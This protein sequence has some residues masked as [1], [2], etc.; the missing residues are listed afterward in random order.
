MAQR[1]PP[2]TSTTDLS[3]IGPVQRPNT[4]ST[5]HSTT[6]EASV[7]V[8]VLPE[9]A[10][11]SFPTRRHEEPVTAAMSTARPTQDA[12]IDLTD[13]PP[14][15][16]VATT[17][18]HRS[19][20][21][22]SRVSS[23]Q[24][25]S[26]HA[27]V[28]DLDDEPD[29]RDV[30]ASLPAAP[31]S[32]TSD[33]HVVRHDRHGL[34]R[35]PRAA[36]T[37][38]GRPQGTAAQLLRAVETNRALATRH[39]LHRNLEHTNARR[40][41]RVPGVISR[42]TRSGA[43]HGARHHGTRNDHVNQ[44]FAFFGYP[45]GDEA[46]GAGGDGATRSDITGYVTTPYGGGPVRLPV[47]GRPEGNA[48]NAVYNMMQRGHFVPPNLDYGLYAR[49]AGLATGFADRFFGAVGGP[50]A[51]PEPM[52]KVDP[53][54]PC[55]EPFTRTFNSTDYLVCP[56]CH[57]ELGSGEDEQNRKIWFTKCGHVYCGA[58]ATTIRATKFGKGKGRSC[59]APG[60]TKALTK[61][62]LFEAYL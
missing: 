58:C 26:A 13:S 25:V 42:G 5:T 28:I 53:P 59:A 48:A 47:H 17:T 9:P 36:P 32:T 1:V 45:Q 57:V 55:K 14:L 4:S 8:Y 44:V 43:Q 20:R 31:I 11:S 40:H 51:S 16:P 22:R 15:Q 29:V 21:A 52:D 41:Y 39:A 10:V 50:V 38:A 3:G 27:Q 18:T 46:G 35:R 61:T 19:A 34:Q 6:A 24:T 56:D 30:P 49:A 12:V 2:S 37:A 54:E 7:P 33:Q 62:K 60:C 23:S